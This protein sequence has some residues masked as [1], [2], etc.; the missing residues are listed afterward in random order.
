MPVSTDY[1]HDTALYCSET[2]QAHMEPSLS[3]TNS[4]CI[5]QYTSCHMDVA[6]QLYR[7]VS[8]ILLVRNDQGVMTRK[9]AAI[10]DA[11]P[12]RPPA[13]RPYTGS[14]CPPVKPINP[15]HPPRSGFTPDGEAIP[16]TSCLYTSPGD[17]S[18]GSPK[19][20][21]SEAV[22]LAR[23]GHVDG[24]EGIENGAETGRW[25]LK[26]SQ[27]AGLRPVYVR[28]TS[29]LVASSKLQWRGGLVAADQSLW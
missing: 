25:R 7:G 18:G 22:C 16:P 11:I 12:P 6:L 28:S 17:H 23:R 8:I 13:S 24:S 20:P 5:P 1:K 15:G 26:A 29:R 14:I 9:P 4:C 21:I 10:Q 3:N 27:F 19:D 2:I